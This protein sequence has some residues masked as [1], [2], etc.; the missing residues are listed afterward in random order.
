M[1]IRFLH[2]ADTHLGARHP[3]I[4]RGGGGRAGGADPYLRN[5]RRA[6]APARA[7]R[8]DLVLHGGDLFHRSRPPPRILHAAATMLT[9]A[10]EGGAH[11]VLVPGNH[12]RSLV[13][14]RLLMS[15]P[16]IHL[17]D[18]PRRVRLAIDGAEVAIFG[19]PFLRRD[20][21]SR[22]EAALRETGWPEGRGD[23]DVLLC[24]QAFD[25]ATVG[26]AN[27]TFRR[28]PDVIPRTF[29]PVG[30]DYLALGHIHRHQLLAHPRRPDLAFAWPGSTE[31]TARAERFEEKGILAGILEPGEPVA[32]VFC[33]LPAASLAREVSA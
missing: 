19:F 10:A 32:P 9:E 23:V 26:P 4:G 16:R 27:Y 18:R 17:V 22:F 5:M 12:E 1:A 24:H 6:L 14:C 7:G 33:R 20:A 31:R 25:G 15:H 2:L 21:R 8:A 11:V 29:V 3:A 13:P 30:F 28:G